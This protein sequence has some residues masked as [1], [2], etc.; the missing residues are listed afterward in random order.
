MPN[1][2]CQI[3][4]LEAV[5]KEGVS[6]KP[7]HEGEKYAFWTCPVKKEQNGGEYCSYKFPENKKATASSAPS[8]VGGTPDGLA[9]PNQS[10]LASIAESLKSIAYNLKRLVERNEIKLASNHAY[11]GKPVE[12][13]INV[14]GYSD[15]SPI[16]SLKGK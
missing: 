5:W 10:D 14:E 4:N 16:A 7:G 13:E 8:M 9:T 12:P 15:V 1:P 3:H 2:R 11:S 6:K